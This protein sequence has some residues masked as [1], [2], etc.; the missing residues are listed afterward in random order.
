M[1]IGDKVIA[2]V[3]EP[4]WENNRNVFCT[5]KPLIKINGEKVDTGDFYNRKRIWWKLTPED[6]KNASVG[7]LLTVEL[8]YAPSFDQ[9]NSNSDR[10]QV[11]FN[12]AAPA[13]Q[14]VVEIV[15]GVSEFS[16]LKKRIIPN[17]R[18]L[19]RCIFCRLGGEI[20]GPF[21]CEPQKSKE[22]PG[23]FDNHISPGIGAHEVRRIP[24]TEFAATVHPIEQSVEVATEEHEKNLITLDYVIFPRQSMDALLKRGIGEIVDT[25]KDEEI[26]SEVAKSIKWSR[27]DKQGIRRLVKDM[28]KRNIEKDKEKILEIV[29]RVE[30]NHELLR[31]LTDELLEEKRLR[32]VLDEAIRKKCE[33]RRDEIEKK[34]EAR[35]Q[36]LNALEDKIENRKKRE[37]AKL[38]GE[39]AK[40]RKASE[41]AIRGREQELQNKESLIKRLLEKLEHNRQNLIE[42]I[43]TLM[44]ILE[45]TG[46]EKPRE[47]PPELPVSMPHVQARPFAAK[48]LPLSGLPGEIAEQDFLDRWRAFTQ[49][50]GYSFDEDDLINFHICIKSEDMN[51]LAGPSGIGKSSLPRLYAKALHGSA[52]GPCRFLMVSVKPG[53]LDSQ[54]LI[55][56]F[57]ALEGRFQ[58]SGTGLYDF[59]INADLEAESGGSGVFFCCLDE[60]NLSH[61]EHYFA[62][63]LS[64][65]QKP[66]NERTLS[67]FSGSQC[68]TEDSFRECDT[69]FIPESLRF[70]GT[71]NVDETTK[72]FSPKVIDRV[73]FIEISPPDLKNIKSWAKKDIPPSRNDSPVSHRIYQSWAR[74]PSQSRDFVLSV[75]GEFEKDTDFL[76][77]SPRTYISLCNYIANARGLLDSDQQAMD[78]AIFQKILPTLRGHSSQFRENLNRFSE[79]CD[80]RGYRRSAERLNQMARARFMDFF[81]Y[82]LD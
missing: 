81:N 14:D 22:M 4:F 11:A 80:R 55:G 32:P 49:A 54:E 17:K 59:L 23:T 35:K 50:S 71:V 69:I 44:P 41:S 61:I 73:H 13:D 16:L 64:L 12:S 75:L 77:I 70:C 82:S 18:A 29:E 39:L 63:F 10:F 31:E 9:G 40:R 34:T 46:M 72:F 26:I 36:E 66:V 27:R 78:F 62:D 2:V 76:K 33:E 28:D 53:W 1:N 20:I 30:K 68:R 7:R 48:F 37:L 43:L 74:D 58:P 38:D 5:L 79:I 42:E 57:N 56:H 45:K 21:T 52:E 6:E 8:Q 51:I 24:W 65:L 47:L 67:L 19:T 3:Y 60:M 25:R 15:N